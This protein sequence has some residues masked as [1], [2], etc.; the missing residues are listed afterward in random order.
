MGSIPEPDTY[1]NFYIS[2]SAFFKRVKR[3]KRVR[4]RVRTRNLGCL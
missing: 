1:I 3:V 2:F 4:V